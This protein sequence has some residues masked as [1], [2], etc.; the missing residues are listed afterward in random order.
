[1]KTEMATPERR[2]HNRRALSRRAH[3]I[4]AYDRRGDGAADHGAKAMLLDALVGVR[5]GDFGTRLPHDWTGIDGKIAD[6]VNEIAFIHEKFARAVEEV[7]FAVGTDGR[8]GERMELDRTDGAWGVKL[9]AINSM[10]DNLVQPV[11]EVGRVIGAVARGTLTES[12]QL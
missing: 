1:M 8:L 7:A 11:R 12:I 2:A 6:T 3:D 10:I 9:N 4:G 5:E